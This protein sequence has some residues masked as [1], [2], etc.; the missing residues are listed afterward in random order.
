[1]E[2]F[3][4][5]ECVEPNT[6]PTTTFDDAGV[7]RACRNVS[8]AASVV[9]NWADRKKTLNE[10][11]AW[12]KSKNVSG[13]DCIIGVSGGKDS[14]RQALFAREIG[15]K[16]LLVACVYP[17]EQ[18]TDRGVANLSN[19]ISL[20]FDTI[21]VAPA[22]KISKELMRHCFQAFG[23][24]FNATE[25]AIYSSLPITAIAYN[26]PLILLGENP[27]LAWGTDV[28]SSDHSGNRM[29][30]T[31][32]LK[33]GNPRQFAPDNIDDRD[34]YWYYYPEDSEMDRAQLQ[35]VYL[36]YFLEDFND[37]TNARVAIEHGM[38]IRTG[39]DGDPMNMGG[40]YPTVALDDDFVIANQMFKYLKF[41]FGKATQEIGSA[42]RHG[43][44]T[45]EQGIQLV[46]QLDGRC[47][48]FYL[49]KLCSYLE[50]TESELWE[51]AD[52]YV[53]RKLFE[54]GP[55]GKWKPSFEIR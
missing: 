54:R 48:E 3:W 36:G 40:I 5:K 37:H 42:I 1:M 10:I 44:M 17:P 2:I 25:L 53:N 49:R 23:N 52:K 31:N 51:I 39:P 20:G 13:Y 8:S 18:Q 38:T 12:A 45:R 46:K 22:P 24:I 15:L 28:G 33:G 7:C 41:G 29:K 21:M 30:Y 11:V 4:C 47:G 6:R 19:L 55:D 34:L 27:G 43:K 16:P 26:I 14:T 9:I 35:I 32:T 50:M